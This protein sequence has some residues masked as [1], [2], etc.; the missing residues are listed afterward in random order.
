M[1]GPINS[2]TAVERAAAL[3]TSLGAEARDGEVSA[4]QFEGIRQDHEMSAGEWIDALNFLEA[5]GAIELRTVLV[6]PSQKER[7]AA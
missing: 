2:G 3:F 4:D 7:Q 5:N 6:I 1:A